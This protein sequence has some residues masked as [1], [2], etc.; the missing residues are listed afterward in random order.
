MQALIFTL[1]LVSLM[2]GVS[3]DEGEHS[4]PPELMVSE[5]L[6]CFGGIIGEGI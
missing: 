1:T 2:S 3:L 5:S 6:A 4:L